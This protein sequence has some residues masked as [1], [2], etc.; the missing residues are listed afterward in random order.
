[1]SVRAYRVLFYSASLVVFG[2]T[3]QAVA[4]AWLALELTGSNAGLGGVMLVFGISML[5]A[6]PVG[7]VAA[8]R[9]PKR[10]VLLLSVLLL[11]V[12]SLAIGVAVVSDV[13]AYWMLLVAGGLQAAAFA[14]YLPAR[15]ALISEVVPAPLLQNAIVLSHMSNEAMRVLAPALAGVLI[16]VAWFGVGGVFLA[17]GAASSVAAMLVLVLPRVP[18]R[19][20]PARSPFGELVDAVRYIRTNPGLGMI[21]LLTVGVV[22]VGYPYL[23]F[24]PA[25][26]EER[27]GQGAV[28]F[29]VMS[30]VAG[31]GALTA[32]ILGASRS[33][34]TRPWRTIAWSGLA[35]GITLIAL[36][37]ADSFALAL[38]ALAGVGGSG[39]IFQTSTQ[40]MM[41]RIS[42][43]EY[44]GRLQS[45]V[46]LGFSGFGLAA[47]P[48]GLAADAWTLRW[49]LTAMGGTVIA[50]T[51]AF[52][53]KRYRDR[54]TSPAI[55]IG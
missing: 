48:L 12:S 36:G 25:L 24:L 47:L 27:F 31:L 40:A 7:G 4:R 20:A 14:F 49:V 17:A 30:A 15:I 29:G 44:H 38:V 35:L 32:G 1:M 42:A 33:R 2:V 55:E 26:A 34:G 11:M 39:L 43:L 54:R 28:G 8:D 9:Y 53:V 41:L 21:A 13:I 3:G 45:M 23:I 22:M 16:G 52:S 19:A 18:K 10:L 5:V 51:A 6:T 46:I 37:F 50:M